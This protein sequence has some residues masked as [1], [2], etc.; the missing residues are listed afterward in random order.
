M[1]RGNGKGI[2]VI[3]FAFVLIILFIV[4]FMNFS[5]SPEDEAT[6]A[7]HQFYQF[8]QSASFGQSWE[9]FHPLMKEKFEK[10]H[11]IQDR[12]H[13]FMN[14]FGVTTFSYQL[15]EPTEVSNWTM[16]SGSN[17]IDGY[18]FTVSKSYDSK[19]GFFTIVKDIYVSNVQGKWLILWDYNQ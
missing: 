14:H 12:P 3:G 15:S 4:S 13:V 11:Y 18:R 8:E 6:E 2:I 16:E 19:Y 7:V 10:S 5:K 17:P 1:K 9:L